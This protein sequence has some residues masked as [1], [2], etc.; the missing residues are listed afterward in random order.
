MERPLGISGFFKRKR[1]PLDINVS[2][3]KKRGNDINR[4]IITSSII[5][6]FLTPGE[7]GNSHIPKKLRY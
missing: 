1:K 6:N 2:R 3:R 5:A 7:P 4:A